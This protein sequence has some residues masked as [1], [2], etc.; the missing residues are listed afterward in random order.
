MSEVAPFL[1]LGFRHI[2]DL[3]ALDHI[4]FLIALVAACRLRDWRHLLL[5]ATAFTVGHSITLALAVTD[6]VR[7]P[8][9]WI[10]FLIPVTIVAAALGNLR[11][12]QR[13]PGGWQRPMLA[14][15]FG[16]VHGAGFANYLRSM[17]AGPVGRPLLAFNLGIET[18]QLAIL[19]IA[20]AGLTGFDWL[21]SRPVPG[22]GF[23]L[24][25]VTTSLVAGL[26]AAAMAAERIPW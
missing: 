13:T 22:G 3:S 9:A 12:T 10:E 6:L 1:T 17:F 24:R 16:L 7:F 14:A 26:W 8:V 5:L 25:A 18:G 23:R 4:L 11:R 21:A 15:V 2:T 20:L 19:A